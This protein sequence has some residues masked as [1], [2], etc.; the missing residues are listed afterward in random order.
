[1]STLRTGCPSNCA[2]NTGD[3]CLAESCY[4]NTLQESQNHNDM[5]Q[6]ALEA[7][8]ILSVSRYAEEVIKRIRKEIIGSFLLVYNVEKIMEKVA[9]ENFGVNIN[10]H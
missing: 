5:F 4:I 3:R 2:Y 10:Y 1:M 6:K 8:T 7:Q 9:L